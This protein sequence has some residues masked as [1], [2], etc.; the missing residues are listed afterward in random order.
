MDIQIINESDNGDRE[1]LEKWLEEHADFD[2][3]A[4]FMEELA[5]VS[6]EP[7]ESWLEKNARFLNALDEEKYEPRH[8]CGEVD[9]ENLGMREDAGMDW[10]WD[11]CQMEEYEPNP[12]D[13][14]Y[15]EC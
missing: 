6:E 5:E 14:T 4:K 12:Y 1:E 13:G 15:S 3:H 8:F 10:E 7:E 9:D 2:V 11:S